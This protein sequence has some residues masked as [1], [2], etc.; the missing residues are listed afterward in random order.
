MRK[1][2]WCGKEWG[3]DIPFCGACGN[4]TVAVEAAPAAPVA[5]VVP[6]EA[7]PA[8]P[9][10]SKK[11][12]I[13]LIAVVAALA[14]LAGV[15]AVTNWFGLV[16]PLNGLAKAIAKTAEAESLTCSIKVKNN[17]QKELV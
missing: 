2:S 8:A 16:S 13:P 5:P 17:E 1:C 7:A 3:D 14:V 9:K 12:L 6:V 4:P 10:K 11:G 15:G